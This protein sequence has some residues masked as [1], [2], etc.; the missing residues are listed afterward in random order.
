MGY[1][2]VN[3]LGVVSFTSNMS[4]ELDFGYSNLDHE[5]DELAPVST[6]VALATD[7]D[8]FNDQVDELWSAGV[9]LYWDPVDQLT[10]GW[11]AGWNEE[12]DNDGT[13]Y[14]NI[15]AGFGAWFRF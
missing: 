6:P 7:D 12:S 1:W 8:V 14:T 4:L 11:G 2:G 15:T 9:A 5:R 13:D 3:A 10:L